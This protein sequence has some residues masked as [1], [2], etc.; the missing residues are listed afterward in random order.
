MTAVGGSVTAGL[1]GNRDGHSWP[2]YLFNYLEDT[3][4]GQVCTRPV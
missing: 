3:Y 4:P 1:H 2:E